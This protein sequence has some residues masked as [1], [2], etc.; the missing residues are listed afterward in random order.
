M[1]GKETMIVERVRHG[2]TT[3]VVRRGEAGTKA[4]RHDAGD[5]VTAR[6]AGFV[7]KYLFYFVWDKV[8]TF[9]SM[10]SIS[11]VSIPRP[12]VE[13]VFYVGVERGAVLPSCATL[14]WLRYG[15]GE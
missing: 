5:K 3:V 15:E 10:C 1:I 12:G 6:A 8:M 14:V 7:Y 2:G 13:K 11:E 9:S 4:A